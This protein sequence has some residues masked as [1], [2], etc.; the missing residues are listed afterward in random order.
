MYVGLYDYDLVNYPNYFFP[1]IELMKYAGF[2][3]A[4]NSFVK[5]LYSLD[6]L[7]GLDILI[8]RKDFNS[9]FRMKEKNKKVIEEFAYLE[10]SGQIIYVGNCFGI[11]RGTLPLE[12]VAAD[13]D[14]LIYEDFI[15]LN[16][17]NFSKKQKERV[18]CFIKNGF[19]VQ[20]T[21]KG[22]VVY[23][24]TKII[25]NPQKDVFIY[26][27]N[28]FKNDKAFEILDYLQG[29]RKIKFIVPQFIDSYEIFSRLKIY[30]GK[31]SG[32]Q[33][34]KAIIYF[35]PINKQQFLNVYQLFNSGINL[36]CE[37]LKKGEDINNHFRNQFIDKGNL[38]LYGIS[39]DK[40][41][42]V[43]PTKNEEIDNIYIS[44]F[45][46]LCSFTR[47]SGKTSDINFFDFLKKRVSEKK[48]NS[49]TNILNSDYQLKKIAN[50]NLKAVHEAGLWVF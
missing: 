17:V 49:Y 39:L 25:P 16:K 35:G 40:R 3:K 21:Q 41:V 37:S 48:F 20:I 31:I 8:I 46:H 2:Y 18:G 1:S 10:F 50:A 15:N 29:F 43:V 12:V 19:P 6:S 22:K 9:F 42:F 45:N 28:L 24:Y 4:N 5:M 13:C 7:E 32:I 30:K 34:K 33:E 36:S 26:D 47:I 44:L 27:D 14:N 11:E 38:F 23:D